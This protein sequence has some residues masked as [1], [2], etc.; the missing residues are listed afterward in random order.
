[1]LRLHGLYARN[2]NMYEGPEVVGQAVRVLEAINE[3][4]ED[5]E[6]TL[7]PHAIGGYA[8]DTTGEPL[9]DATLKAC[10]GADAILMG[11]VRCHYHNSQQIDLLIDKLQ[12]PSEARSGLQEKSDLNKG[13]LL[14]GKVWVC[15]QIFDLLLLLLVL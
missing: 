13:C 15:M 11:M 14:S 4:S 12:D 7:S 8:I 6:L 9:P 1:M 10:Q 5:F 3:V 2:T